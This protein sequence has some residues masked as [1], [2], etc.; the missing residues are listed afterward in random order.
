MVPLLV[1]ESVYLPGGGQPLWQLSYT[2]GEQE[3][4]SRVTCVGRDG[5]IREIT[6]RTYELHPVGP[7]ES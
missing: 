4:V 3:M 1:E 2:Y 6:E 5:E 7:A